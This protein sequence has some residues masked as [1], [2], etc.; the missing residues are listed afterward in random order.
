MS[1][2]MMKKREPLLS[3]KHFEMTISRGERFIVGSNE[4]ALLNPEDIRLDLIYFGLV[5]RYIILVES[6][7]SRG[8]PLKELKPDLLKLLDALELYKQQPEAEDFFFNGEQDEYMQA[9]E[10]LSLG[11]LLHLDIDQFRRLVEAIGIN[12]QDYILDWLVSRRLPERRPATTQLLFPKTYARLRDALQAPPELQ[13]RLLTAFL[14]G[15]YESL[16]TVWYNIHAHGKNASGFTGYWC[17]E[18]A[19]AAYALGLDDAELQPLRY[20]PAD[21][22]DYAFG[23]KPRVSG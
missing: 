19:A 5:Q 3:E 2:L 11:L 14:T 22:A 23:R 17:W 7:Y 12:G 15:W 21:L 18:A 9:V 4:D 16:N 1:F 6:K 10:L 8:Y 13:P 20:Y